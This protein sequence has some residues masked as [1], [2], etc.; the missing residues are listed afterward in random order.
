MLIIFAHP[1]CQIQ[2]SQIKRNLKG[3]MITAKEGHDKQCSL[4][5]V[6]IFARFSHFF[7]R[8][9]S[10][11]M[12][13]DNY[14][15]LMFQDRQTFTNPAEHLYLILFKMQSDQGLISFLCTCEILTN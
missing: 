10:S 8:V 5:K 1:E 9:N 13:P 11:G 4:I 15:A 2:H 3:H 6:C 14:N 12:L 7:N